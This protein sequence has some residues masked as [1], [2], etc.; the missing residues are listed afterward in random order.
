MQGKFRNFIGP[1]NIK[2]WVFGFGFRARTPGVPQF[3]FFSG[4]CA[5]LLLGVVPPEEI[6]IF[7][8]I[9]AI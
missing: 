4:L 2:D 5:R 3:P 8:L 6:S 7:F 9:R 1:Q